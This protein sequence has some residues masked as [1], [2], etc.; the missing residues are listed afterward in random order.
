VTHAKLSERRH[1]DF[2]RWDSAADGLAET[3]ACF[4]CLGIT[5]A[6][7]PDDVYH[8]V[9]H[10]YAVALATALCAASPQCAFCFVSGAGADSTERSRTMWARVKG[11]TENAI[12]RLPFR[13][14]HVF[15]PSLIQPLRGVRSRT[16]L[17]AAFYVATAP[18]LPL[19][20]RFAP[21]FV[22]T[23]VRLGRAMITVAVEGHRA[24]VLGSREINDLAR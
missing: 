2:E 16:G 10:D 8:R 20:L 12:L 19:L 23:T 5:S 11:K 17:Y 1:T 15:R 22:T 24:R 21:G 13:R 7:T 9:T 6:G 3:D 18:L 4:Y 14:A